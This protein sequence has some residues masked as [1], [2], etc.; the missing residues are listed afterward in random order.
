MCWQPANP[1][2]HANVLYMDPQLSGCDRAKVH[3]Q[4]AILLI[5]LEVML[6]QA[7]LFYPFFLIMYVMLKEG[8][9][10]Q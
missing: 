5:V 10:I 1:P 6:S 8:V 9:N 4:L 7:T 3:K 2:M